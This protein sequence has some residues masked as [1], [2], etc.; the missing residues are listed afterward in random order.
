MDGV[1]NRIINNGMRC[2]VFLPRAQWPAVLLAAAV[3]AAGPAVAQDEVPAEQESVVLDRNL[4]P[5][6]AAAN[7]VA[8]PAGAL[9]VRLTVDNPRGVYS[10][11]DA[12]E[13]SVSVNKAAYVT[14]LNIGVDGT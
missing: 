6:Q 9:A 14:V 12:L 7:T 1:L 5:E 11:G 2:A 4:Q 13:L 10:L 3:L 8:V